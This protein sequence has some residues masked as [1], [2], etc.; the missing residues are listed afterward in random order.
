MFRNTPVGRLAPNIL[1]LQIDPEHGSTTQ[2]NAKVPGPKMQLGPVA[3]VFRYSDNFDEKPN[4]GYEALIYD[5]MTGDAT[6]F[7]RADNI[8]AGW[9][10]VQ[11]LIDAMS[12]GELG[13]AD[14]SA[15]SS[16]PVEA[17]KL[18]SRNGHRWLPLSHDPQ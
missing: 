13:M 11:P 9:A 12:R 10:A 17:E 2:F 14:Y 16:G 18:L 4:V 5:C 3:T 15:G 6:L 7:Q 1:R 8:E